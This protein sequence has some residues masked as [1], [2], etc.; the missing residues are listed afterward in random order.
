MSPAN[1]DVSRDDP[2]EGGAESSKGELSGGKGERK[3]GRRVVR[4][5]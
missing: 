3:E 2:E 1:Q 5:S 4:E